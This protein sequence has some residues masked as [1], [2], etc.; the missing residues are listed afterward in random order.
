ME[1]SRIKEKISL[2]VKRKQDQL[3]SLKIELIETQRRSAELQQLID[4]K[5]EKRLL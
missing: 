5:R 3:S 2:V 4:E 1:L